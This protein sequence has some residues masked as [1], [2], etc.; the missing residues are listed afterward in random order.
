MTKT[1]KIFNTAKK[2]IKRNKWLSL[3]TIFVSTIVLAISSAFISTAIFAQKGV[4]YYEQKAQVIIFFKK[5]TT[6]ADILMLRDK[7]FD[8]ELI[9]GID[10]VSQ[11]EALLIYQKDFADSP[12]LISTVTADSLPPSLEIRAKS[13]DSLIQII[14]NI[15]LEKET[16]AYI[17]EVLYFKDVVENLRTLSRIIGIGSVFLITSL[18]IITFSLIRITIGFNIN[19][20]Q[21]EIQIMHLVGSTDK[22]IKIPFILE[23]CFY[24]IAGG[25]LGATL[26]IVPWYAIIY[27]TQNTD[28]AFWVNQMLSDFNLD[29]LRSINIAF[30]LI[31]YLIH[32][33]AGGLL[34]IVSSFSAVKR[35]LE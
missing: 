17:D 35:Y 28:F 13:I 4:K 23:G 24:G 10:Y 12:D 6:E 14:E 3:S 21:D 26:L 1:D 8:P 25:L 5:D 2:N 18:L 22:F 9:E 19:A 31:Y 29:F 20:H 32:M 15:N 33:L 7:L 16:N 11:E 30:I 34:G 27:Y